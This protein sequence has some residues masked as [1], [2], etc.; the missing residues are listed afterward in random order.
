MTPTDPAKCIG[1]H[2]LQVDTDLASV[3]QLNRF[4]AFWMVRLEIVALVCVSCVSVC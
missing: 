2:L 1:H 4:S 3:D